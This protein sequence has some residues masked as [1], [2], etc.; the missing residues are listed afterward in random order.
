MDLNNDKNGL[1]TE[2]IMVKISSYIKE[3]KYNLVFSKIYDFVKKYE[4]NKESILPWDE[5]LELD[6]CPR[7]NSKDL[8]KTDD[9][10]YCRDCT[11]KWL[12]DGSWTSDGKKLQ[13]VSN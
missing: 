4:E 6:E 5:P 12:M 7:C 8:A 9:L 13:Y 2:T 10:R 3:G 1:I 11:F